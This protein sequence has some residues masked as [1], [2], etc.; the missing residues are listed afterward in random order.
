MVDFHS[1][2]APARPIHQPQARTLV[3]IPDNDLCQGSSREVAG[4]GTQ[5]VLETALTIDNK[6]TTGLFRFISFLAL[7]IVCSVC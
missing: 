6:P 3:D 7:G 2:L 4:G 1:A 5:D